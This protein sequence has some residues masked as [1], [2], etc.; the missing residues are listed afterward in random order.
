MAH[1]KES[2]IVFPRS[3]Q[4]IMR[5]CAN[6][7]DAFVRKSVGWKERRTRT[8]ELLLLFASHTCLYVTLL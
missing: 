7:L 3:G 1:G 8:L 4:M 2:W 5:V 6:I